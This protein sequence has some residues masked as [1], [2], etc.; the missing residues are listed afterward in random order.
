[1]RPL[2]DHAS[3]CTPSS[4]FDSRSG[5]G[6]PSLGTIQRLARTCDCTVRRVD[7][8]ADIDTSEYAFT[9]LVTRRGSCVEDCPSQ[10]CAFSPKVVVALI[11]NDVPSGSHSTERI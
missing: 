3:P 2:L 5:F 11:M 6:G 4:R 1:M 8:S 10:S 7:P 9:S